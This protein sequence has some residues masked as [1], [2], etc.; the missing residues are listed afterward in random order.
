M[1]TETS[2]RKQY[3]T[4][5]R[6]AWKGAKWLLRQPWTDPDALSPESRRA[7]HIAMSELR[8][9]AGRK[10]RGPIETLAKHEGKLTEYKAILIR[11]QIAARVAEW[12]QYLRDPGSKK[13][14]IILRPDLSPAQKAVQASHCAAEF[15][16]QHPHAPW[17]N[18]TMVLLE[19][20]TE[21]RTWKFYQES[22][23]FGKKIDDPFESF[24]RHT[25][26]GKQYKTL[27]SE[28]DMEDRLTAAAVLSD[29]RNQDISKTGVKLI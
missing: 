22:C 27:W 25:A 24:I 14:F 15:Q 13:L 9:E 29:F 7:L 4:E 21:H 28:P 3:T 12:K 23:T 6:E 1:A 8:A 19:P 10:H 5:Q 20:D 11:D 16:K 17:V 2:T 26:L 18:G